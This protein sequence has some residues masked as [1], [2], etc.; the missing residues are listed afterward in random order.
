MRNTRHVVLGRGS[1]AGVAALISALVLA[2][3]PQTAAGEAELTRF[4]FTTNFNSACAG[5]V[6]AITA[7]VHLVNRP[8]GPFAEH[9][10]WSNAT[11][12]GLTT[13]RLYHA[14]SVSNLFNAPNE[15]LSHLTFTSAGPDAVTAS[16]TFMGPLFGLPTEVI[17]QHCS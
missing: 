4:S 17:E 6:I 5:E 13:G 8:V 2:A 3:M 14:V 11:G 1:K 9:G 10:S 12:V 7:T 16:V 15:Y